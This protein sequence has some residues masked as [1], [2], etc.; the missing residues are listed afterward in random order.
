MFWDD[1][2]RF[3]FSPTIRQW[4]LHRTPATA[5]LGRDGTVSRLEHPANALEHS[6]QQRSL[7]STR[8]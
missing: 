5:S 1:H 7:A 4:T 8:I 3:R 6:S 2:H